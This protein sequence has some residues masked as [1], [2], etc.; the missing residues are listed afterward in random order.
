MEDPGTPATPL[1]ERAGMEEAGV[2]PVPY[3]DQSGEA[4]ETGMDVA[5]GAPDP[6]QGLTVK[7][8]AFNRVVLKQ[9]QNYN[10]LLLLNAERLGLTA[11]E[12]M[13]TKDREA[14][15]LLQGI[16][17]SVYP[18]SL[19]PGGFVPGGG[20]MQMGQGA[21]YQGW[22]VGPGLKRAYNRGLFS[23]RRKPPLYSIDPV[24][25]IPWIWEKT[26]AM[27]PVGV[28]NSRK[29]NDWWVPSG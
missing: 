24:S 20:D 11:K 28:N 25:G 7:N 21:G 10:Q 4:D 18:T 29:T 26:K 2:S 8:D 22:I 13:S 9:N 23:K 3:V 17:T 5:D 19:L 16:N 27:P 12:A 1:S 15:R 6:T 14:V